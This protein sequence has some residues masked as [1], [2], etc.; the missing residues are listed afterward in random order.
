MSQR[1]LI[2]SLTKKM[3]LG[4]GFPLYLDLMMMFVFSEDTLV[5]GWMLT[6]IAVPVIPVTLSAIDLFL[7]I[8]ISSSRMWRC[9]PSYEERSDSHNRCGVMKCSA[10]K[11]V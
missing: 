3:M 9:G 1:H 2:Y 11:P 10:L 4:R 7:S 5:C 8:R 6:F